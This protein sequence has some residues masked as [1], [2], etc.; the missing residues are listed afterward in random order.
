MPQCP[1]PPA[2]HPSFFCF[3][4]SDDLPPSPHAKDGLGICPHSDLE[5][6]CRVL[7]L[8]NAKISDTRQEII[9]HQLQQMSS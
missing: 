8:R 4:D 3:H 5:V 1:Y 7:T 6:E 9:T 2:T